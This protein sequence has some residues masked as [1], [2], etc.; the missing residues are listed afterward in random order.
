MAESTRRYLTRN[1]WRVDAGSVNCTHPEYPEQVFTPAAAARLERDG[2]PPMIEKKWKPPPVEDFDG[3]EPR[4]WED[5]E[6]KE[7]TPLPSASRGAAAEGGGQ[8][9]LP[10]PEELSNITSAPSERNI[11]DDQEP[12]PATEVEDSEPWNQ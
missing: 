5:E 10:R 7:S 3:P 9:V 1:G 12:E 11:R 8:R 6:E 4:P 2:R